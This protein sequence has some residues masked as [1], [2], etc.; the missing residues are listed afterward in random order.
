MNILIAVIVSLLAALAHAQ[1]PVSGGIVNSGR[2]S[3]YYPGSF[4][5]SRFGGFSGLHGDEH[6]FGTTES[7]RIQVIPGRIY[8]GRNIIS[9]EGMAP[10]REEEPIRRMPSRMRL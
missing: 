6:S 9:R 2:I 5:G 10:P 1:V 7:P 4:G 3:G 8:W